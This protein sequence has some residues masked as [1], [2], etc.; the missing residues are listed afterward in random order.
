MEFIAYSLYIFAAL[1]VAGMFILALGVGLHFENLVER[2]LVP[3]IPIL[4]VLASGASAVL[5]GRDVSLYGE[6][7]GFMG[8]AN[9]AGI[10]IL[11]LTTASVVGIS[12]IVSFSCLMRQHMG[13]THGRALFLAFAAFFTSCYIV[14]GILGS[15]PS[16]LHSHFYAVIVFFAVYVTRNQDMDRFIC[17]S[18]NGLNIFIFMGLVVGVLIPEVAVQKGYAG[19]IPGISFR[20]WGLASHANNLGPIAV[21]A[22]LL[23]RW[24]PYR[25]VGLNILTAIAALT[26]LLLSQ[27]KT[28]LI[29]GAAA[30]VV[31]LGY[32]VINVIRGT[33]IS[34]NITLAQLA[35]IAAPFFFASS[36]LVGISIGIGS[37]V[38]DHLLARFG[39]QASTFTGRDL[40][41]SVTLRE[42]EENPL[43]GY[44][45]GLW[46]DEFAARQ[47]FLGVASNAH[48]Q[49]VDVL[50]SS[51]LVGLICFSAYLLLLLRYAGS[52]AS[53]TGGISLA[54]AI[55]I[56][57][58][59]IT[60]VPL[61]TGNVTTPDF[62]IHFIFFGVLLR[63]IS[64][65][66]KVEDPI[67]GL[68]SPHPTRASF[69]S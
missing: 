1:L 38:G 7:S 33:K 60:E 16:F 23:L 66:S 24:R 6:V 51:G 22:L 46:G 68:R 35:W 64:A 25:W 42:W 62:L 8:A 9:P 28:A 52:L 30:L 2:Y 29:A 44:G 17:W 19:M 3:L 5:S 14:S 58:R 12:V 20:F 21:V 43:F 67:H 45:P 49:F 31:L 63:G 61:K 32:H 48:N 18:R 56:F 36:L 10:W 59:C 37:N 65:L 40:I 50:G 27:S 55:F 47:G 54:F 34:Q 13:S 57:L 26:S 69:S 41:W 39:E 53:R 11:R 4:I 15:E